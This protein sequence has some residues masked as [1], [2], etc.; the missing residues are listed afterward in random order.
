MP[1]SK[2]LNIA[3]LTAKRPGGGERVPHRLRPQAIAPW[4]VTWAPWPP[5]YCLWPRRRRPPQRGTKTGRGQGSG[6]SY[7]IWDRRP[8]QRVRVGPSLPHQAPVPGQQ[9]ASGHDPVQPQGAPGEA[10]AGLLYRRIR[11]LGA[12]GEPR[13]VLGSTAGQEPLDG[14]GRCRDERSRHPQSVHDERSCPG[15]ARTRRAQMPP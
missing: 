14:P 8:S 10:G 11:V 15:K 5:S 1:Q 4:T 13:P 3:S 6:G 7:L 12:N 9:G 2:S